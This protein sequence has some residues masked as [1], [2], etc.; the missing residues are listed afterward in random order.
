MKKYNVL[1]II[2][3]IVIMT[4]LS[5]LV[6]VILGLMMGGGNLFVLWVVL[7]TLGTWMFYPVYVN[8]LMINF[9]KR[10][11]KKKSEEQGFRGTYTY[12]NKDT[13]TCGC[14]FSI[15]ESSGRVAYVSAMNPFQ[16]QTCH[17]KELSDLGSSYIRGPFGGTRYV[18]FTFCYKNKRIK[19][20]TFTSRSMLTVGSSCVQ[21][22]LAKGQEIC[23]LIL[24]LQNPLSDRWGMP[25]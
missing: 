17:A 18:Y 10:T 11:M 5:I 16:F 23:D 14:V 25:V 24:S 21:E 20:P 15:D 1:V 9:A 19:I 7:I 8:P 6:D 2:L 13:G 3:S 12:V 4:L 22:A